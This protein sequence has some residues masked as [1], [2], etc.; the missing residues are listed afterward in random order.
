M[1]PLGIRPDVGTPISTLEPAASTEIPVTVSAPWASAYTSPSIPLS[2]VNTRLPPR[3]LSAVPTVDKLTSSFWP[4]L[5]KGG[6]S[7]VTR[8]AA[9]LSVCMGC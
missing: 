3:R 6:T 8:T 7:A 9:R 2:S 4:G 1:A 5:A